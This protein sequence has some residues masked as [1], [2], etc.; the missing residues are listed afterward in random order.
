MESLQ[1]K[2]PPPAGDDSTASR[3]QSAANLPP[4]SSDPAASG[5]R[6]A[7]AK[8]D[9][10]AFDGSF[11]PAVRPLGVRL[12]PW[13]RSRDYFVGQWLDASV[14]K[15]AVVELVATSCLVFLSGQITA[16]IEGYGTP[17]VG[18][19][20]G[21]SNIILLSTFIYATAPASGGHL[22]PTITFS[23]ILTGLCSVPRGILYLFAQTI[24]GALAGGL[25]LGVWGRERATSLRGGG[26]W[27]DP[28]QA[29]PGQIYLN[30]V[31]SSFVL[32]F[33]SFGVGLDPRQAAL[34]GPRLGPLL[35]GA[36]LGLV[37][38]SSS[39][40]IPGYAGAQMNPSRCLAFG[41]ARRNMSYQWVWWFGP[42]VAGLMMG[43]FYNLIPPHHTELAKQ[44]SKETDR[45]T[46]VG[47][48][49]IPVV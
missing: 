19:Y 20:I 33:L 41:I 23:A 28:S 39:G 40:I 6:S 17:Q 21:I 46:M 35:V 25:L 1:E 24:G 22:N 34:F 30:E 48:T 27:Y 15:S 38:F 9:L 7:T 3:V 31:F 12:T 4:S 8:M 13:Y 49:D 29:S 42:A 14:W 16:T 43:I 26:C 10:A 36:S 37:S 18:G 32:L 2:K 45:D 47:H 11:A 44:K 5:R